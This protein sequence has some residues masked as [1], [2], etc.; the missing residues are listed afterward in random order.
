MKKIKT[1]SIKSLSVFLAIVITM[2][3]LPLT[4]FAISIEQATPPQTEGEASEIKKDIF[5]LTDRRTA[6]TKYFRLEDGTVYVAQYDSV[7]HYL[8]ENGE[9][10]DIDNTLSASGDT[11]ATS[12]QKIKFAKKTGGSGE[13]FTLHDGNRKLTLTLQGANKKIVGVVTNNESDLPEDAS[14]LTKMT[15][16]DKLSASILYPNILDNTDL[17]YVVN[18]G[19][20]KENIIVK[21]T[22]DSYVYSFEMNL[23]N[24]TAELVNNE[25]AIKDPS[26]DE[27]IYKIPAP[28]MYDANGEYSNNVILELTSDN[29]SGKYALAVT[30]DAAWINADGRAFPVTIDPPVVEV[31]DRDNVECTYIDSQNPYTSYDTSYYA[32]V[33]STE[34]M[35][36]KLKNLPT[37]P[38]TAFITDAKFNVTA[39][40]YT[41]DIG[42]IGV[43]EVYTDWSESGFDWTYPEDGGVGSLST[44]Y[45]DYNY[46]SG[47]ANVQYTEDYSFNITPIVK[48][49]YSGENYGLALA[50]V[51]GET[52]NYDVRFYTEDYAEY[53]SGIYPNRPC[54][55]VP[56]L[57]ISYRDMKGLESYWSA[58]GHSAGFAGSGAVNYANGNL[59]VSIPTLT[60]TDAL[61]PISPAL[62]YCSVPTVSQTT[63]STGPFKLNLDETVKSKTYINED[64]TTV[65]YYM[66]NDSDGTDH[67]FMPVEGEEN[68]FK[69]EDGLL[70]TLNVLDSGYTI[71]DDGGTVKTFNTYG[72]LESI[73]DSIGHKVGLES[74]GSGVSVKLYPKG[75][76]LGIE[77]LRIAPSVQYP[78]L[79]WNPNSGEAV[80]FRYSQISSD[81]LMDIFDC[82]PQVIRAHSTGNAATE[83]EWITFANGTSTANTSNITVD[84]VA[85]Y[86]YDD[87]GR[88]NSITNGLSD[89]TVT[90]EYYS[91]GKIKTVTETA[92]GETGQ[93]IGFTY[94]TSHTVV[95]TSGTDDAYNT[96]DDLLTTYVFDSQ[97]RTISGYTTDTTGTV[98]HGASSAQYVGEENE[99][100][101]N[102]IKTAVSTTNQSANYI[103]NGGFESGSTNWYSSGS[104]T[105]MDAWGGAHD[106]GQ[107]TKL[108]LSSTV[109]TSKVYQTV[110]LEKGNYNLSVYVNTYNAPNAEVYLKVVSSSNSAHNVTERIP[111]SGTSSGDI[112]S[113]ASIDF[114][115]DPT[116]TGGTE[117]FTVYVE[118]TGTVTNSVYVKVDSIMLSKGLGVSDMAAVEFG[119]FESS[120]ASKSPSDAWT[121]YT[122]GT[123][124]TITTVDSGDLFGNVL[125]LNGGIE[126][127]IT[128]KQNLYQ[129]TSTKIS[130]Y[131]HNLTVGNKKIPLVLS[132]WAKSSAVGYNDNSEFEIKVTVKY[133][134]I[135]FSL[136]IEPTENSPG[137]IESYSIKFDKS[138]TGWQFLSGGFEID[139]S[140]GLVYS[141]DVEVLYD[142]NPGYAYFDNISIVG[143][144]GNVKSYNYNENGYVDY[145]TFGQTQTWYEYDTANPK[146]V[147]RAMSDDNTVVK[148]TYDYGTDENGVSE[149]PDGLLVEEEYYTYEGWLPW[150]NEYEGIIDED[151]LEEML[152]LENYSMYE[153]NLFGQCELSI[154]E[155][156]VTHEY[157]AQSTMYNTSYNNIIG[158]V[159]YETDS[160]DNM[161]TY[162]YDVNTGRLM[163]MT[164]SDGTGVCYTYDAI[165]NL[166][167]VRPAKYNVYEA[168]YNAVTN[169]ESVEYDYDI[170]NRLS[171]ITTESTVYNF[172]YD[173]FGNAETVKVGSTTLASYTYN[174]N[175]GKI[176]TMTYGNGL[177]V[178]YL[179]DELD[180]TSEILY[181]TGSGGAFETVAEYTYDNGGRLYS[182]KDYNTGDTTYYKYDPS[183]KL[184]QTYSATT[185]TDKI[186][187]TGEFAYN[188]KGEMIS[189]TDYLGYRYY[190]SGYVNTYDKTEYAFAYNDDGTLFEMG[191][192][193]TGNLGGTIRPTYDNLGMTT[194]KT[195]DYVV[196]STGVFNAKITYQYWESYSM[197]T[198]LVSQ[199]KIER[200]TSDTTLSSTTYNYTYDSN[201]N[202]T[203][204]TDANGVIQNRY[205]YD[206]L[207]QLIREDNRALGQTYVW[208]YDNAGNRT[209]MEYGEFSLSDSYEFWGYYEYE[210]SNSNWGD[211]LTSAN[212][213]VYTYDEIGNPITK[214]NT[215]GTDGYRYVWEGRRLMEI[216]QCWYTDGE[217]TYDDILISFTY[218]AD[219]IRTGMTGSTTKDFVLD[220]TRIISETSSRYTMVYLYDETGSPIGIKYRSMLDAASEYELFFFE[221]NLQGDVVAI[222]NESGTKIASYTYDAWGNTTKTRPTS[223]TYS[224]ADTYIYNNNPFTYRSYYYDSQTSLYYLQT[225]YYDPSIGRFIN[226][227]GQISGVGGDIIGYNLYAYCFNNPVNMVDPFGDW[228]NWDKLFKGVLLATVGV[229]AVAAVALSGGACAPLVAVGYAVMAVS[230]ATAAAVGASEV[231]ESITD[232]NPLK[233][234]VGEEVY[235]GLK[236]ISIAGIS[237]GSSIVQSAPSEGVCF[238]EG[239]LVSS[240]DGLIPIEQIKSG[241]MVWATNPATDETE[242]KQVVQTFVN[243]ANE[244]VHLTIGEETITATPTH[245]FY[246]PRK[247]WISAIDLRA[248]DILVTVNGEYVVLEQIQH[249]IL[250]TPVTVYNFEVEDFHTYHV[251]QTNILVHNDCKPKSP[252][253]VSDSYINSNNIDAHAFKNEAA[254]IPKNQISR[255][256]IYKDTANKG[257]LWVGDKAGKIWK[258]TIY[259]FKDLTNLWRKE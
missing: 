57:T 11:Y 90:Y 155:D 117:N 86:G 135:G 203:Q 164:Y 128:V 217:L 202:I 173:A 142:N 182:S 132:A 103:Y 37:I 33:S 241:D 205:T 25:I 137:S 156:N 160:I 229:M 115:A 55:V 122:S 62:V 251:G 179:Y 245:P 65:T 227:D 154:F 192:G 140:K 215:A 224:T 171:S 89:Y 246:V 83:A 258:E 114:T 49:W 61:M 150:I 108:N 121:K 228:P 42:Y 109:S 17:E 77:Q 199:Y 67:A 74:S 91:N 24:F 73:T 188:E 69:D 189:R 48:K 187:Y 158:T 218:N 107:Y 4:A 180:R 27:V 41:S 88:L 34:R 93:T 16:L 163:A 76:D 96:S 237:L 102:N 211:Q 139:Q 254:K 204:I 36:W 191:M 196:G 113:F 87:I 151:E 230:G 98:L 44:Y 138:V 31:T 72:R 2:L 66:W 219:G 167:S 111:T 255:Y 197:R 78:K 209:I 200:G 136:P 6:D 169:A 253:K 123:S 85:S 146:N 213:W 153:Y 242:L 221:K 14:R 250:E 259:F 194:Q 125:K 40:T 22:A 81:T 92:S 54:T 210:Y 30:A 247:G 159:Q 51:P 53:Y 148:Y 23:N 58:A 38:Q 43:Y 143:G 162:Y 231:Y 12:N 21:A 186:G 35:Y 206:E 68:V 185:D 47:A 223:V 201:G 174:D 75:S 176:S 161:T 60:T 19:N 118:V 56:T 50:V 195:Y 233:D 170:A 234:A 220:G 240:S 178:K 101:K 105:F 257:K 97:G 226:A 45:T 52:F 39:Y 193:S 126:N 236:D 181:N 32:Y 190:S 124:G 63:T 15:T 184:L 131:N 212:G 144:D 214:T 127:D 249:E 13:I 225:R 3:S 110:K 18:S 232:E 8:D 20:I 129:T 216:W 71:T 112:Y 59:V 152:V 120:S 94:G 243:E 84:A 172:T 198:P 222:Y 46:I 141:V 28:F 183:G 95:R 9:W 104:V 175:N 248:G 29:V 79:V 100:A 1:F 26:T 70:L 80:I 133:V 130:N 145:F 10:K 239:T 177:T 238:V 119:H 165:G 207:G 116:T 168:N 7:I 208:E 5:E 106:G 256:D 252:S 82:M 235:D 64:K 134:P 147:V 244:L 166:T 157:T 149:F 99:N